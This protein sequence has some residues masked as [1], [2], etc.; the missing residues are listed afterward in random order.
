MSPNGSAEISMARGMTGSS[1]AK[2]PRLAEFDAY[3]TREIRPLA[4][5]LAAAP[6]RS[7]LPGRTL[8]LM[9]LALAIIAGTPVAFHLFPEV[10]A[11]YRPWAYVSC[12]FL[13]AGVVLSALG[14]LRGPPSPP[15][16][17]PE[18][19]DQTLRK[20]ASFFGLRQASLPDAAALAATLSLS[21]V[22]AADSFAARL[23]YI[24]AARAG[25]ASG[26]SIDVLSG[27][28]DGAPALIL[29]LRYPSPAPGF[30]ALLDQGLPET[31][32]A[33]LDA[34]ARDLPGLLAEHG[35]FAENDAVAAR[36]QA[37]AMGADLAAAAK[38]LEVKAFNVAIVDHEARLFLAMDAAWPMSKESVP[39]PESLAKAVN[40]F[41]GL[42]A[43]AD[44][45]APVFAA[46]DPK[47][48]DSKT[49]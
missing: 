30:A 12:G 27:Q 4:P 7:R 6:P 13:A 8:S 49:P 38:G 5:G 34:M 44:A 37:P 47:L 14:A 28:C 15:P 25:A 42:V 33:G 41:D 35:A 48:Q 1:G 29:T 36:L 17:I 39:G 19:W 21:P 31:P 46:S 32:R 43:F 11:P 40:A 3:F 16:V 24:G 18:I 23:R 2:S 10:M 9:A 22:P 26:V 20:V 45:L